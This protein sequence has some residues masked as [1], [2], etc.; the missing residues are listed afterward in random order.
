MLRA[1]SPSLRN[2]LVRRSTGADWRQSVALLVGMTL[3]LSG[4]GSV[5]QG[6]RWWTTTMMLTVLVLATC[7]VLR[8]LGSPFSW[9]GGVVVWFLGLVWIFV[10]GTMWGILPTPS[11]VGALFGLW[12]DAKD[13]IW[14]EA[15]PVAAAKPIIFLIA[16]SF[17]GLAIVLDEL[18]LSLRS[19]IGVGAIFTAMYVVPT[20]VSGEPPNLVLFVGVAAVWLYLLRT[21]LRHRSGSVLPN[22]VT[23]GVPTL[24]IALAAL[25]ISVALPP[26]LPH[27]SNIAVSWGQTPP[28]VF[29]RGINPILQLGQN[30]RRNSPVTTLEYTT[31]ADRPPYLKVSNLLDFN[32][33]TWRPHKSVKIGRQEGN[34]GLDPDVDR[35]RVTTSIVI[36]NLDSPRMPVPYPAL[37]AE[38]LKGAW[39]WEGEGLTLK[40]ESTSSSNQT[41]KVTSLQIEPTLTQMRESRTYIGSTLRRYVEVPAGTPKIVGATA[42]DVTKDASNDYDKAIALQSYFRDNGGFIYSETAPVE[43]GYDGNGV[44]VLAEFLKVKRGYCVHYSS[45]MALMARELNIPARI[46]VGYA[47]GSDVRL[48]KAGNTVYRNSSNDL[49]AWPELYFESIGWIGFEPTPSVGAATSFTDTTIDDDSSVDPDAAVEEDTGTTNRPDRSQLDGSPTTVEEDTTSTRSMIAGT[50]GL[51]LILLLPF[52]IR[53][54]QR[55]WYLRHSRRTAGRLWIELQNTA[56][57]LGMFVTQSDTPRAFA[58][59]LAAWPGVDSEALTRM[60][61]AVELERFGPPGGGVDDIDDFKAVVASIRA[62]STRG[63]R[64]RSALLPRSIFGQA[65]YAPRPRNPQ[66][67]VLQ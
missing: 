22:A 12:A 26:A 17:V 51:L 44:D 54:A 2:R 10:P 57:D 11:S 42:R 59:Q 50:V 30:L 66:T 62:G 40:S 24:V 56:R 9:L 53:S 60:L 63:Q 29:D 7:A 4:F 5:V 47:P 38:G 1:E 8:A 49:H 23:S 13:I 46:A 14:I 6:G 27:V 31:T 16:A 43:Q 19:P 67:S 52:G 41:Y 34:V 21:E 3:L 61:H 15:S 58:G 64:W 37:E 25:M 55:A 65:T 45:A 20:A 39:R 28:G 35:K 33:K 32:G 48:S 36:K 18:Q